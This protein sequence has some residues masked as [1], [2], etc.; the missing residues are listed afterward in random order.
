MIAIM[1]FTSSIFNY[2]FNAVWK[3]FAKFKLPDILD[4]Q[5][6]SIMTIAAVFNSI[7]RL[8]VGVLIMKIS[9]KVIYI[10]IIITQVIC[11]FSVYFLANSFITLTIFISISMFCIGAHVTLFPTITTKVFGIDAGRGAYPFIYQCFSAAS[12][13]QMLM[14]KFTEKNFALLL[15]IFGG[16]SIFALFLAIFF[17]EDIDWTHEQAV[18]HQH[19]KIKKK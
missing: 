14:Y 15:R 6:S 2:F 7:A 17:V 19:E 1:A 18:Y 12:L 11:A 5:V 8:L 9:F 3:D 13:V 10:V 4:K 16:M